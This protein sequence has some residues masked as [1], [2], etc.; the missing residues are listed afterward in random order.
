MQQWRNTE[1]VIFWF[2]SRSDKNNCKF[3]KYD[4]VSFYPSI[5]KRLLEKALDFAADFIE[6]SNNTKSIIWH[7]RK[8]LLFSRNTVWQKQEDAHFDVTMGSYDGAELIG[9]F[10]LHKLSTLIPISDNGLYRDDGLLIL[11]GLPGPATERLNKK[12]KNIFQRYGLKITT[13][14]NLILIDFL[15]ITLNLASR[16]YWPYRKPNDNPL[17]VHARSNHPPCI[18]KQLPSNL[19]RRVSQLSCDAEAFHKASPV[20]EE[21]LRKSE[22]PASLT[23]QE[24]CKHSCRNRKRKI[25]WFNPR[26]S[27]HVATN[28]GK[29]F[30]RL[31][32]KHFPPNHRLHKIINRNNVKISY[33][34]MPNVKSIISSHNRKLLDSNINHTTTPPCNCRKKNECP[35]D[36]RCR[37]NSIV[38]DATTSVGNIIKHY[39]GCTEKEFKTRYYNHKNSF[40][41]SKRRH[42]TALSNAFWTAKYQGNPPNITWNVHCQ[43]TPY[44]CGMKQCQLC[45]EEKLTIAKADKNITLNKRSELIGKCRHKAKFK[46]KSFEITDP[47]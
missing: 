5:S 37:I 33:C 38:Y 17:Y 25:I 35:L 34:C 29:E 13:E 14:T 23:Y 2:D 22:Y 46:L 7:C 43:V 45:L 16:R 3:L 28:V 9:L 20:Y 4:I 8:S 21:A 26:F 18:K 24:N 32:S 19:E 10:L 36:G 41:D 44:Q 47:H 15:D 1:A 39:Y 27:D 30:L 31:I 12:I 6:I 42:A 40:K 11:R